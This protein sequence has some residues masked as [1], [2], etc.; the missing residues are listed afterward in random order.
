MSFLVC[1]LIIF[2]LMHT[3]RKRV[4][5]S[6]RG[7]IVMT[8]AD[9]ESFVRGVP[10]LTFFCLI[11]CFCYPFPWGLVDNGREDP[12]TMKSGPGPM[13]AQRMLA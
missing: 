8:C 6:G 2:N 3:T 7:K 1:K 11:Y 9:P 12:N 4:C 10:A 5:K 13:M